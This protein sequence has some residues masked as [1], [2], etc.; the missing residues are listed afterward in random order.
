LILVGCDRY[1]IAGPSHSRYR[2]DVLRLCKTQTERVRRVTN[3]HRCRVASTSGGSTVPD[4]TSGGSTVPDATSG[5]STVPDATSGGSVT[6]TAS[7][8]T[9]GPASDGPTASSYADLIAK[10]RH[11]FES[12][13]TRSMA[14]RRDQLKGLLAMLTDHEEAFVAALKED[15]GRPVM[16]AFGADIGVPRQHIKHMLGHFE[17]WAKPTRVNPGLVWLPGKGEI[18]HEPVGVALV[19][20]PYNYPIQL[21]VEPMAAALAAGNCVGRDSSDA[22]A[23]TGD[24]LTSVRHRVIEPRT[25]TRVCRLPDTPLTAT[26]GASVIRKAS[27]RAQRARDHRRSR[28]HLSSLTPSRSPSMGR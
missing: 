15:L 1:L 13:R 20:S 4:A 5:G 7:N 27:R 2:L 24:S 23:V 18:I 19:I 16:E 22:I 17:S 6:D 12:G 8:P 14:W 9:T 28:D 25:P 3:L 26:Y 11:T 21:L 10:L